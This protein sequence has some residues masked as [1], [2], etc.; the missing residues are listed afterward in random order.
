MRIETEFFPVISSELGS[1]ADTVKHYQKQ[2][3]G[4]VPSVKVLSPCDPASPQHG[5]KY[6]VEACWNISDHSQKCALWG[7]CGRVAECCLHRCRSGSY[8]VMW[9][10]ADDWLDHGEGEGTVPSLHCRRSRPHQRRCGK[11]EKENW[12]VCARS[13][14]NGRMRKRA[15]L[16]EENMVNTMFAIFQS[17]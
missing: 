6:L 17:K 5:H 1:S 14:G 9:L 11:I 13:E 8:H 10:P 7:V 4:F 2:L 3:E 12:W 15:C 16:T